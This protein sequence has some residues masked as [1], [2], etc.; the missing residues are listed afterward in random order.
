MPKCL[1]VCVI[2][3]FFSSTLALAGQREGGGA[4]KSPIPRNATIYIEEMSEGLD[5][6]IRAEFV[7]QKLPLK[8]VLKPEDAQLIFTGHAS[9]EEERKWHEGWLTTEKDKTTANA[10]VFTNVEEKLLWAGEA[11]DRSIWWGALARGGH[12]KVASRLVK[13]LK[14][15]IS[16]KKCTA[17]GVEVV[18][19]SSLQKPSETKEAR[20]RGSRPSC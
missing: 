19:D 1:A 14:R 18:C 4:Q 20:P 2:V 17:G 12:R 11:G 5:G 8:L 9:K 7:K 3:V 6:Y 10:M 13:Q 16:N 15:A